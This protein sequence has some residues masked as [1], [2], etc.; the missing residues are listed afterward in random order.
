VFKF[1]ELVCVRGTNGLKLPV[2][3]WPDV[4]LNTSPTHFNILHF[5]LKEKTDSKFLQQGYYGMG[6]YGYQDTVLSQI[7]YQV[8]AKSYSAYFQ[9]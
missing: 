3:C 2:S 7:G 8:F 6:F 4:L 9:Q 5:Y 1:S